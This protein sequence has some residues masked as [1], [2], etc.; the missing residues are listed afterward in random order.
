[1]VE[2]FFW[3]LDLTFRLIPSFL[4]KTGEIV[5]VA[6]SLGYYCSGPN[7]NSEESESL[8]TIEQPSFWVGI[9]FW[10]CIGIYLNFYLSGYYLK[11]IWEVGKRNFCNEPGFAPAYEVL[12]FRQK[13]PKPCWL[14]R[15]PSGSLRGSP[16]S[17]LAQTRCA[18]TMRRRISAVGCTARPRQRLYSINIFVK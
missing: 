12:L 6:L 2:I 14:W 16:T 8:I 18:Q 1:M 5:L 17:A 10:V 15:G 7:K 9:I 11:K 4:I 3:A 13:D